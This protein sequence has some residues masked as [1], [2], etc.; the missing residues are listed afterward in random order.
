MAVKAKRRIFL[1]TSLRPLH[2]GVVG[3]TKNQ[4]QDFS[5]LL[6]TFLGWIRHIRTQ[7][8]FDIGHPSKFVLNDR[9]GRERKRKKMNPSPFYLQ[10]S[11]VPQRK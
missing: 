4:T 9:M 1:G 7:E 6:K 2:L 11:C 5:K 10:G 8:C 3:W